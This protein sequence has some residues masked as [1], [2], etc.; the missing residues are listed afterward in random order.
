MQTGFHRCSNLATQFDNFF[1]STGRKEK[2]TNWRQLFDSARNH[3]SHNERSLD[4]I[5]SQLLEYFHLVKVRN[6]QQEPLRRA[7]VHANTPLF[8]VATSTTPC[9]LLQANMSPPS[10]FLAHLVA[11][12]PPKTKHRESLQTPRK[13]S[14]DDEVSARHACIANAPLRGRL[15]TFQFENWKDHYSVVVPRRRFTV[16]VRDLSPSN[17]FF[18]AEIAIPRHFATSKYRRI[19]QL[20]RVM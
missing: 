10:R 18:L 4:S 17:S 12:S 8:D 20:F 15:Y 19:S 1:F 5:I 6:S 16:P 13:D 2:E 11:F 7:S 3:R 9:E 14:P